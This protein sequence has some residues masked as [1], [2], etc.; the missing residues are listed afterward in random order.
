MREARYSR[1]SH[2]RSVTALAGKFSSVL[3]AIKLNCVAFQHTKDRVVA[4]TAVILR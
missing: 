3:T 2:G 4:R 1:S